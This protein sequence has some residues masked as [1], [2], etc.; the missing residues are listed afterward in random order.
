[1]MLHISAL[2]VFLS[3]TY[4]LSDPL[5]ASTAYIVIKMSVT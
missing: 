2:L 5:S 4:T 1:M 3:L